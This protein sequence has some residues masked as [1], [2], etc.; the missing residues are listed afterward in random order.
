MDPKDPYAILGVS[1]ESSADEIK[2]AYRRL[3]KEHHPD[4][5]RGDKSAEL[6][7]KEIQAAYDVLGDPERRAQ[8]DR[9]GAGG[10]TP[11]FRRWGGRAGGAHA[12]NMH[13][14]LNDLG[15]L[16]SIFEQFFRRGG[17]EDP[18]GPG[19]R[20]RPG[21]A[22][23]RNLDVEHAVEL[24]FHESVKGATREIVLTG[25]GGSEHLKVK[26][27]PGITDGQ[28][29]RLPGKGSAAGGARGD[30]LI[31]CH[32]RPHAYFRR[33]GLD[34][35]LEVPITI[36]EALRG[37]TVEVPTLAERVALRV[38]AGTSSGARLRLRERGIRDSRGGRVGDL[39]A[40]IRI[41]APRRISE[42][43]LRLAE[44]I[45]QENPEDPRANLEWARQE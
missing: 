5:N 39:Y 40:V 30:L 17:M 2:R 35:H 8:Y 28:K 7:F 42:A 33:D 6:R 24:S 23:D 26:I 25:P 45:Q 1:R 9:F 11:E 38:P 34:L 20:T 31:V 43:A 21:A 12:E 41:V 13:A 18:R 22:S 19:A 32:V 27:P 4:R 14:T 29:I 36:S 44:Q 10:P 15:D 16:S 37:A 3:A